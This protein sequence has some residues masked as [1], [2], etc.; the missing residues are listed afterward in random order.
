MNSTGDFQTYSLADFFVPDTDDPIRPSPEF[1]AW[2]KQTAWATSLYEQSLLEGPVPR[3]ALLVD[4]KRLPVINM[5]SYNYLGLARHP[6]TVAAAKAALDRYGVGA[7]GSPILSGMT[8]LHRQLESRLSAF[9]GRE[10]TMLFNSGFGGALGMLAGVLRRGDAAVMDSKCHISL[11]EGAKLSGAKVVP[12]D[13]NSA[14]SLEACLRKTAGNRRVVVTEGV[15]SMD[16]DLADL[17][18]LT[19]VI[20]GHGVGLVIDEAHSILTCGATGQ[21]AGEHFGLEDTIALKYATFSKA[22][23]AVGGFVS[24]PA[25]TIEYLRFFASSYGF[26]CALPPAIVAAVLAGLDIATRDHSLQERLAE[27]SAYFRAQLAAL[28]IDTGV[29]ASQVVPIIIGSDRRLLYEL[30]LEM[31]ARGLFLAPVDYPSVPEDAVRFR[32]SVTA[33]HTRTDLDEALNIIADVVV[34]RLEKR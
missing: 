21:G 8:D 29:S 2:R 9:L 28:G 6:E 25:D 15:F 1:M 23:G 27:N 7:C 22:F 33:E 13:H 4:G 32:A 30:G 5:A 10:Q 24:G 12:F 31:R 17:P 3:T 20:E 19:P 16:G 18:A 26:S 14:D 11:V 34:P